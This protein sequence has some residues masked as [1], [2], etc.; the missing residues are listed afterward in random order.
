MIN[1][2]KARRHPTAVSRPSLFKSENVYLACLPV[3]GEGLS[4]GRYLKRAVHEDRNVKH[5]AAKAEIKEVKD[6]PGIGP[7]AAEKLFGAGYKSLESI[8]VASPMELIEASGLGEGTAEKAIKA[9]RDALE[10][11][12]ESADIL[13]ERRKLVGRV[14]T[15]S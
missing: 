5:M 11:G 15:G 2:A 14:S 7:Q 10:M 13:A 3:Q 9:A 8:A 1:I 4:Q 6:L 12:Y